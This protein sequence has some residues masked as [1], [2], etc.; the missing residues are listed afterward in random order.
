MLLSR[1]LLVEFGAVLLGVVLLAMGQ[2]ASRL[3]AL[4]RARGWNAASPEGWV[5][6]AAAAGVLAK[7]AAQFWAHHDTLPDISS[8]WRWLYAAA[9]TGFLA[10][11]GWRTF[12]QASTRQERD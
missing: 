5:L 12:A 11:Q 6:L 4:W 8:G 3:H 10:M 7:F 9:C 2:T 1:I